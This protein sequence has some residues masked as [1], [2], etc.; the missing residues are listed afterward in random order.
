MMRESCHSPNRQRGTT[1]VVG[2]VMLALITVMVTGAFTMSSGN[3]KSVGNM[4]LRN[5]AIA[6]GNKAIEQVVSSPFTDSPTAEAIDVDINNDGTNDYEVSF[7]KPVCVSATKIAG[8]TIPPSSLAL[9]SSFTTST[10]DSYQTVWDL[11]AQVQEL[12]P[13]SGSVVSGSTFVH[14]HEGVR[15]LLSQVQYNAVCT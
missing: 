15:V 13:S 12:D 4:Q 1:L 7:A 6:A 2:L 8:A 11:D 5:E 14:V 9:G 3:L 10:S